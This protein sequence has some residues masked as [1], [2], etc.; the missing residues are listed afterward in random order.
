L[1]VT[2]LETT[3]AAAETVERLARSILRIKARIVRVTPGLRTGAEQT[4]LSLK[5]FGQEGTPFIINT[6]EKTALFDA[7]L[8]SQLA[9][10]RQGKNDPSWIKNR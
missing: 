2:V 5:P 1:E 8:Q 4:V 3:A 7:L 6:G 9:Y 10:Q